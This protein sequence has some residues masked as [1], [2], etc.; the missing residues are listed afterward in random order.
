MSDFACAGRASACVPPP[1]PRH[2]W[3]FGRSSIQARQLCGSPAAGVGGVQTIAMHGG[4]TYR[5]A[6]F[7]GELP[8]LSMA[9]FDSCRAPCRSSAGLKTTRALTRRG[10]AP[11]PAAKRAAGRK[12]GVD[13]TY[14]TH[15]AG[16]RQSQLVTLTM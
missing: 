9:V 5:V 10:R 14:G 3:T 2:D 4:A 8:D 1:S 6:L 12:E 15:M 16:P 11:A 13:L 7:T